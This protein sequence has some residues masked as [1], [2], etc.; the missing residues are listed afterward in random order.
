M[1][2]VIA[3]LNAQ[4]VKQA[5]DL[6]ASYGQTFYIKDE[7]ERKTSLV[8]AYVYEAVQMRGRV[9]VS[10]GWDECNESS[11]ENVGRFFDVYKKELEKVPVEQRNIP[12]FI[13]L[14]SDTA[15]NAK[16]A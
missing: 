2:L 6:A 3:V 7:S 10:T 15:K 9:I 13:D 1:K 12:R 11:E 14:V 16:E 8:F 5:E 4:Q